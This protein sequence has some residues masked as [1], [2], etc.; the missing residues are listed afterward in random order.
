MKKLVLFAALILTLSAC[1][2]LFSGS[3]Q[4]ISFDSN[5]KNVKIYVDGM[6]ICK[7]PCIFPLERKSSTVIIR[8]QK[9]GFEDKQII[10]RTNLN[11][12]AILNLT[13]WPS[14]LTDVASG[15][16]WQYNRDGVYIDM[17][18]APANKTAQAQIKKN[19]AI[20]RFSLFGY[21]ELKLEA[22]SNTVG[23]YITAL[24]S[25]SEIQPQTLIQT[26]RN[27]QGAVNLAHTLT[28]IEQ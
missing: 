20:R 13:S 17:E 26:I 3:T 24:S 10:L 11:K 5:Q 14:W 22:A 8:A 15:G 19:V 21:N 27:S 1:G 2:T 28:N 16:M 7:T 4:D 18:K 25:L 9:E 6:E 12:L 23:E